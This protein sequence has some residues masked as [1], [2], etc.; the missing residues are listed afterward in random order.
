MKWNFKIITNKEAEQAAQELRILEDDVA[1][2]H[3]FLRKN[4]KN[5][6]QGKKKIPIYLI[7]GPSRFGKTTI[8]S[9]AGLDLIDANNQKLNNVSPTKYCSFWFTKDALYIDTAGT[10]T[11]P[12]ISKPRNDLIWQGFIK[13]LQKYFG[14]DS[15][16]GTLIILDLPAITQDKNL[17]KKTLFCIRERIYEMTPLVKTLHT[18]I[19]FTKCDCILGFTEF[20]SLLDAEE[21]L[22]PLGISFANNKKL[23]LIPAFE[24]KFN[25]LL[26]QINNRV[27]ENL[28]KSIRPKERSLIKIFPSQMDILRQTFIEVISKIP[29][30]RQILLS[31]IY[32]TSSIQKG[33]PIDPIKTTLL[34]ALNLKEKP[35]YNLEASD[36]RSYFV[37][38]IF[39]KAIHLHKQ[40][41]QRSHSSS[42]KPY[43]EYLYAVFIAGLIISISSIV[44]YQS[45]H[46]NL[47]AIKKTDITRKKSILL[48]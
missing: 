16:S 31:G 29:N 42:L 2:A 5:Y 17:L 45:Y 26:K 10:Y 24:D 28:Q 40:N 4:R 38:D 37:E 43:L 46:K 44:G 41:K 35:A 19:I 13:L 8:L 20:F 15:I 9:R 47:T 27:V 21:R 32:F 6:F 1:A 14:K 12:D 23:D 18:H 48:S 7:L 30:S 39:K 22:Q 11:K 34:H 33:T 3:N 36:D 25:E